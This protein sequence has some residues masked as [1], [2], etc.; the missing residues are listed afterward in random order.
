MKSKIT[1]DTLPVLEIALEAGDTIVAEPGEFSWMT[2]NVVLN[3]T[4][5][6]A[7]AKG[8]FGIIGRALAGGGLFMTE[9]SAQGGTGLIAFASKVPGHI[10]EV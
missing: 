7:G 4:P 2:Q 9:Y 3:T 6:A 8:L 5:M 10:V 1:G